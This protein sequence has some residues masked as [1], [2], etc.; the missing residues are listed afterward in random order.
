MNSPVAAFVPADHARHAPGVDLSDGYPPVPHPEVPERVAQ[1][2]AGFADAWSLQLTEVRDG[3]EAAVRALHD[4]DYVD[5]LLALVPTLDAGRELVPSLFRGGM[6]RAPLRLQAGMFCTETGTPITSATVDIALRSARA[7]EL[8]AAEIA[9]GAPR[10][11]AL[12]RPP[13]HH[14]SRRRYGGYC[15]FNNAYVAAR[16]IAGEGGV[17]AVLDVDYHLGD[18]SMEL[19][20]ARTP[21]VSLHA[22]PWANYPCLDD[23]DGRELP[24]ATL[25]ALPEGVDGEGYLQHLERGLRAIRAAGATH[26]V[27]S[28]G[29]DTVATDGIQDAAVGLAVE[30]YRPMGEAIAG[31]E[32][33]TLVLLEGGYDLGALRS[34]ARN[35]A[36][37][38]GAR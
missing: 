26:L 30:D 10:A 35:F 5:W 8:A 25:I 29:F 14:A 19:A 4:A 6:A 27:V 23:R 37:G 28:L 7:A 24:H 1:V 22:D 31:L 12:C 20:D 15:Y 33:P 16:R 17:C 3:A 11:L 32:L 2:Q 9:D 38:L 34:C 18:G 36:A 21:Y 13:G